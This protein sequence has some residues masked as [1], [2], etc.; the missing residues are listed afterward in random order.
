[1]KL[2]KNGQQHYNHEPKEKPMATS[3]GQLKQQ[4]K[5]RGRPKKTA[6]PQQIEEWQNDLLPD[7][8]KIKPNERVWVHK[9][10]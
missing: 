1:M 5:K 6:K 2:L 3:Q 8:T 10:L 4:N 9:L 7:F